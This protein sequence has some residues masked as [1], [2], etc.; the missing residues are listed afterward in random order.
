MQG[1]D[2]QE[3]MKKLSI[4]TINYN[5]K[6]GL[7]QTIK[8]VVNQNAE[9]HTEHIIIDGGSNDGSLDVI[10]ENKEHFSYWCSE[11][12][13]GIYHA[14]NKGI[15]HATGEYL[16]FLNSGD[17]LEPEVIATVLNELTGTDIIYGDIIFQTLNS[18]TLL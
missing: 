14:M 9:K 11:K 5:N 8:S 15:A 16:L 17:F 13:N 12:D 4:I 1:K 7:E 18:A 6:S 2:T 10:D 3:T